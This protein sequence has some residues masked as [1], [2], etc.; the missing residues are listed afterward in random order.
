MTTDQ[1]VTGLSPVGVT[2]RERSCLQA[3]AFFCVRKPRVFETVLSASAINF[4]LSDA[5]RCGCFWLF[6]CMFILCAILS[7]PSI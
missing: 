2:P 3:I 6:F 1:K 5:D 7:C 4:F